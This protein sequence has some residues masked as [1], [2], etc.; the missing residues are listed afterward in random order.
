M[1]YFLHIFY[2]F[3]ETEQEEIKTGVFAFM[4]CFL[5]GSFKKNSH[6][7]MSKKIKEL[8]G[9]IVT[10]N[11][12]NSKSSMDYAIIGSVSDINNNSRYNHVRESVK[13]NSKLKCVNY[14]WYQDCIA[15]NKLLEVTDKYSVTIQPKPKRRSYEYI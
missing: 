2:I 15:R 1:L 14:Q 4:N 13:S 7:K 10:Q 3:L 9:Y 11:S 12:S 5:V 6:S 8:N